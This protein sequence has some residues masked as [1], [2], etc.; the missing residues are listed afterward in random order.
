MTC[1]RR[2]L[3]LQIWRFLGSSIP[4]N[5]RELGRRRL[6]GTRTEPGLPPVGIGL[7]RW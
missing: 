2:V 1:L 4:I 5:R 6:L 7:D 3:P